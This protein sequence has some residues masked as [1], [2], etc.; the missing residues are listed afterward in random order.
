MV[1]DG[2]VGP[3]GEQPGNGG[4]AVAVAG[5][6]RHDGVVLG[7]GEGAVL[8]VGAELVAPPETAGLTGPALDVAA[9]EGPVPRAV[10]LDEAGE[11]P[12]LLGAPWALDPLRFRPIVI[13]TFIASRRRRLGRGR[14]RGRRS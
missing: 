2:V 13:V 5:V 9:D 8:D 6:S 12:V 14:V 10:A 1:L 4:P 3:A 11:D 7:G